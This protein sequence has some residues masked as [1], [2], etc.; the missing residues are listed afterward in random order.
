MTRAILAW[1][2]MSFLM[3]SEVLPFAMASNSLPSRIKVIIITAVSKKTIAPGNML[4]ANVI[5]V[6][7][8][9]AVDV[10]MATSVSMLAIWFRRPL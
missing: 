4:G 5:T 6:L 2:P 7:Y 8:I 9:H 10:P 1:S 3:A